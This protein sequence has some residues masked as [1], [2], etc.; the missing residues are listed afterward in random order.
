MRIFLPPV[1]PG[2][3]YQFTLSGNVL[4][5]AIILVSTGLAVLQY[6]LFQVTA[7][8]APLFF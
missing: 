8:R 6:L 3:L 2:L 7:T 1:C 5:K 4:L